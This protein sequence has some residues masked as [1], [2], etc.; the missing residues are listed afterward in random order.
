MP[1]S[2]PTAPTSFA[3][4]GTSS[5]IF[6]P[7]AGRS[8]T[9]LYNVQRLGRAGLDKDG[10]VVIAT[11]QRVYSLLTGRDLSEEDEEK[12]AFESGGSEPQRIVR[13]NPAIPIESFDLIITDEC[14][15]SIYGT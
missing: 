8:F 7:P 9:E 12:S 14:H 4:R 5:K 11:I 3:R 13:Y 2:S 6:A 1:C 10:A 15:R